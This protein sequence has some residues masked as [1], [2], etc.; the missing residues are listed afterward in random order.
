MLEGAW[1]WERGQDGPYPEWDRLRAILVAVHA[2]A[3]PKR[4]APG[5]A[6]A[7][8]LEAAVCQPSDEP[9]WTGC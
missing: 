4:G 6:G 3:S 2:S 5:T 9:P 1:V 8:G 7:A